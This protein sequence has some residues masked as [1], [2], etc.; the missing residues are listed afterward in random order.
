MKKLSEYKINKMNR[1]ISLFGLALSA[2]G[3]LLLPLHLEGFSIA[4]AALYIVAEIRKNKL[5]Y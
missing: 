1:N 5:G 3:Q 4:F 2:S